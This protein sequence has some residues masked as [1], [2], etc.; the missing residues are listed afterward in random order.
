MPHVHIHATG[1]VQGVGMRPFVYREAVAR[2]IEGWVRN[3][4]DG[5]HIEAR[6]TADALASFTRALRAHAPAA[7]R[8]ENVEVSALDG[9]SAETRC[10]ATGGHGFSILASTVE[11]Q[12]STLVSPDIAI[13]DDCLNELFDERDRRFHYPF[14]NCTN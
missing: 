9:M 5:V 3:A 4:G 11:T 6:G 14:I 2:D 12:R 1:I 13:C 10:A 8:I 7:A